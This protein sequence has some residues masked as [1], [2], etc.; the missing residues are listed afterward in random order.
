MQ[1]A[2][3]VV[4]VAITAAAIVRAG[5]PIDLADRA[6]SAFNAPP[7]PAGPTRAG[8]CSASPGAAARTTGALPGTT[9]RTTRFSAPAP[10][11][12]SAAGSAATC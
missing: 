3:L 11:A 7:A 1:Q 12:M 8:A 5:G 2:L 9:S 4:L 6:Y 10:A